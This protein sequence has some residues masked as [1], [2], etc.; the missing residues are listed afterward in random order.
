MTTPREP[1]PPQDS[2][3]AILKL[4]RRTV[5]HL[6]FGAIVFA[7]VFAL[8][9]T[10]VT[11][12]PKKFLSQTVLYYQEGFQWELHGEAVRRVGQ[13]LRES[14]LAWSSLRQVMTEVDLFPALR[15]EGRGDEALEEMRRRTSFSVND[16]D[17]FTIAYLGDTAE[18]AELVTTALAKHLIAENARLRGRQLDLSKTF[19]DTQRERTAEQLRRKE[20]ELAQFLASHPELTP[21]VAAANAAAAAERRDQAA[22]APE[23]R[24]APAAPQA[25]PR[26]EFLQ[27]ER[28]A[29]TQLAAVRREFT[30]V[31]ARFTEKHP[32][33]IAAS[34]RLKEAEAAHKRAADALA[35]IPEPERP[36]PPAVAAVRPPPRRVAAP[37]VRGDVLQEHARL[38]R[39]VAEERERF[40]QLDSKQFVASMDASSF[41]G[42]HSSQI[43]VIDPAFRPVRPTGAGTVTLILA[44]ITASLG[45]G[46]AAAVA[47]GLLDDRVLDRGDA[48]QWGGLPVLTEVSLGGSRRLARGKGPVAAALPPAAQAPQLTGAT[49]APDTALASYLGHGA[50]G[51]GGAA[52]ATSGPGPNGDGRLVLLRTPDSEA[53]AQ[54]RILRHRIA[55]RGGPRCI[56]VTSPG[57][58]EGKTTCAI[59]LALALSEAGRARVLLLDGNFRAP[60]LASILGLRA[61]Q[62]PADGAG[63]W[64][65]VEQVTPWL[66]ASGLPRGAEA[67]LVDGLAMRMRIEELGCD[68]SYDYLVIDAPP[69]L[70]TADVNMLQ[71]SASAVLVALWRQDSRGRELRRLTEQ[72]G[73]K[74]LLGTVLLR[75]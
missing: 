25:D 1:I 68:D 18:Q 32:S 31:S 46:F 71:E 40:Q 22:Q 11:L 13:R 36:A 65:I 43:T 66:S 35:A 15:A 28:Q 75:G 60:A 29:A 8:A 52:E 44:A 42:G 12:R 9:A 51:D 41:T 72:L 34:E 49:L 58:G 53:A 33:V 19:L 74:R 59:N 27:A 6:G 62:A 14:V 10:G 23:A 3:L 5:R 37:R 24:G 47:R 16:G 4:G 20:S 54:F 21:Q 56:L 50:A 2:F 7:V 30:A 67:R 64:P 73:R 57:P 69:V 17:T 48:E 39:E 63:P 70:G 61:V 38:T 45:L 55:E 26:A